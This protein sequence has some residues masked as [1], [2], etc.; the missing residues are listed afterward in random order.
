MPNR[1]EKQ[2]RVTREI[3]AEIV[4]IKTARRVRAKGVLAQ[5]RRWVAEAMS[6]AEL[7]QIDLAVLTGSSPTT[8]FNILKGR[9]AK[10]TT[11]AEVADALGYQLKLEFEPI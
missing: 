5:M 9:N 11:L 6:S 1:E 8:I 10:L 7:S 3:L 2:Q 4:E